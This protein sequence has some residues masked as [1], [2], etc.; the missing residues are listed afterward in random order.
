MSEEGGPGRVLVARHGE[1][2][3]NREGRTQGW[4]R[5]PLNDRGHRQA[6]ALGEY[7]ATAYD[8]DHVV[9]SD[10]RRT[11]E[12]AAHLANAGLPSASFDAAW[13]ERSFGDLQGMLGEHL[14]ERHPE[15]DVTHGT[16][17]ALEAEPPGGEALVDVHDRVV[18][19]WNGLQDLDADTVLVVAHGG[20]LHVLHG[21]VAGED[22][23]TAYRN[24]SH[25]NCALSEFR[26]TGEGVE[27]VC[28]NERGWAL[29]GEDR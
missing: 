26:L 4:A 14:F 28:K 7:L 13:R 6:A 19:A 8:I 22:L 24:H 23:R 1:T 3:W 21:Y 17:D 29:P 12:T 25:D 11:R 15:F 27:V 10:L 18:G 20:P 2:D 5:T 9:A 16:A